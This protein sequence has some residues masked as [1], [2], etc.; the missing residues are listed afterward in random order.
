MRGPP[1]GTERGPT[2]ESVDIDLI[3]A[4]VVRHARHVIFQVA[5][6]MIPRRLV[7]LI[8]RRIGRLRA[9]PMLAR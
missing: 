5:E 9:S 1:C 8:V 4:K 6:T 7:A 2:V 3:G